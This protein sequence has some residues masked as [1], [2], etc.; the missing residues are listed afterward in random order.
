MQTID[1]PTYDPVAVQPLRDELTTVGF[2]ET[3][4]PDAVKASIETNGSTLVVVNSVCG[5]SAGSARPGVCAALQH[6]KIPDNL[7]TVFAGQDK[8]AVAFLRGQYLGD[9]APSSPNIILFNNGKLVAFMQRHDIQGM[10][11]TDIEAALVQLFDTV[12]TRQGPSIAPD[13]YESLEYT[14]SCGSK[15]ARMDGGPGSC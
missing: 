3:T 15:I 14:I 9:F 6:S 7:I 11:P 2:S 8:S 5:C 1:T 12:C 13:I 4:T 10:D